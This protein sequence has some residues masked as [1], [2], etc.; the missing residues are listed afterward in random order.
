MT[1]IQISGAIGKS[2]IFIGE[3][4]S[5]FYR[6]V[7]G[8]RI[9]IITDTN[10]EQLYGQLW[11]ELPTII[12]E[13]GENNK[14]LKTVEKIIHQL[15]QLNAGRN[16]FLLGI[17]GGIVC[18]ITGFVASIFMRGVRF[19]FVSTTLLSQV[20]ASV[21]GKNGVNFE[22]YKNMVGVFNQPEFVLCDPDVLQTLPVEEITNG[23]AEIVK[24]AIIRDERLFE[25]LEKNSGI[26]LQLE[27]EAMKYVVKTSV[28]IKAA[29]VNSDEKELGE[30]R[31][32]NFGH[33]FGHAIE[34]VTGLSHGKSVSLGMVIASKLSTE[35]G[36][37]KEYHF[38][39]IKNLLTRLNLPV[40]A[41]LEN[42]RV[43]EAITKD[44]KREDD[45][46]YFILPE[47]PGSVF[48]ES[49]PMKKI[50]NFKF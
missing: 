48:I 10:V 30:R 41:E 27:K 13:P 15:L 42:F 38:E 50:L 28:Q 24:Y 25:F 22:G 12:T 21:G 44:K 39:R 35:M 26:L 8:K 31:L 7:D 20:D 11:S 32:L 4:I 34:K 9:V 47:K 33:T 36:Y 18:D 43:M 37:L 16:T 45:S 40:T 2:D 29:I 49:L 17:G 23:F 6:Y 14:T 3:S 1:K 19:G 46:I 5:S